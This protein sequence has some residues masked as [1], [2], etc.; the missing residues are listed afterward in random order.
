[1]ERFACTDDGP[2]AKLSGGYG[3]QPNS[4]PVPHRVGSPR[5][6]QKVRDQHAAPQGAI[7]LP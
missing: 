3:A 6:R 4:R 1:M 5:R 7:A 2:T